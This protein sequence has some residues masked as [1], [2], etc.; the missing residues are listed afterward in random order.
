MD[1]R[2][3][4]V[5]DESLAREE[6]SYLIAQIGGVEIVGQAD[7]G[8]EALE[9]IRRLKHE[10][11]FLDVQMPGLTGFQVARHL[12]DAS[13]RAH[14]IFVTA[15]DQHAIEAFDV[16]AIDYLLKPVDPARLELALQRARRRITA[17]RPANGD[18]LAS[19]LGLDQLEKIVQ[20]VSERQGRRDQLAIK[21]ACSEATGC[22]VPETLVEVFFDICRLLAE[23]CGVVSIARGYLPFGV[24]RNLLLQLR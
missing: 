7:N 19:P 4:L 3:V 17:D 18:A 2:A 13:V 16:N 1:L 6:L 10:L 21:V 5:D 15:F 8:V 14:V 23:I 12:V 24:G 9:T 11:V 20:L 22:F